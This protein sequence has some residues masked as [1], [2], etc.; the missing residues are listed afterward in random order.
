MKKHEKC[1]QQTREKNHSIENNSNITQMLKLVDNDFKTSM[2][3]N[4][5]EKYVL[6]NEQT[7]N[8]NGKME[9]IKK[10]LIEILDL[11]SLN[12]RLEIG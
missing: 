2:F 1:N 10:N 3:K 4:L 11:G 7:E 6:M 8:L 5:K 9:T 12:I